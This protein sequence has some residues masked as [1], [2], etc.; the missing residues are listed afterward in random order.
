MGVLVIAAFGV[1][2]WLHPAEI[3]NHDIQAPASASATYIGVE[4][5]A[6]CHVQETEA[7][8]NSH[9]AQAMQQANASTVLGNF[10][11]ARFAKDGLV[12]SFYLK[13][14][15]YY[16]R[17]DGADGTLNDYP[18]AYTF[19]I[20]PLQQYLVSFPN[21]YLQSLALAW[22]SRSKQHGGQHWFHLYPNQT[23]PHTDPLHWTGRNQ[24]WNYMCAECHSTNLRK[25]YDLEKGNYATTWSE[26]NV[27]CE[28]CHGPGSNHVTWAQTQGKHSGAQ[29]D[30]AK[31]LVVQLKSSRGGW[32]LMESSNGTTHWQGQ[33]RSGTELATCAPCHSR[34]HPIKSDHQAGE[35]FLDGYLPSL[36]DEGVYFADGQIQEEDYE[37]GSFVQSRMYHEG[38]TCSDCHNP[39]SLAF[40]STDLN[41]ECGNC[42]LLGKFGAAEHHRHKTN[43]TGAL[44]VNCHMPTRTYMVTDV[45]RD[46][47]F[48]MPRPDLSIAYGTPNA[49]NQC[50]TDKSAKWADDAVSRWYGP[51]RRREPHFVEALDA[52]RR[53]LPEAEKLLTSLINDSSK[54]AIAR[55]TALSLIR[56][57]LSGASFPAVR[58]SLVDNDALVRSAAVRALEPLPE[59][60]RAQLAAPLLTD[61]IRAVRIE[62]ARLLAGSARDLLQ[63]SQKA[64]LDSAVSERIESELISAERPESHMNLGLL[65]TQMGRMKD[66]EDELLTALRLDPNYVPAMVNLA[67]LFRVQQRET[68]AQQFLEKAIFVAPQAA[69]PVHAL[70]LL[71]ARL[72]RQQEALDLFAKAV[73]L[74]PDAARYA[75]V[76][77]VALHSYGEVEKAIAVLKQAHDARPGDREVLS[78]LIAFQRDKGD[79]GSAVVYAEKLVQLSPGDAQALA[80]RNSLNVPQRAGS[81]R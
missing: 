46:H 13:D 28:S 77:G 52:G 47:S 14:E 45:R 24:T 33:A 16:V 62:A 29:G 40:P 22:D 6:G 71:K 68:E 30:G 25:N 4:R 11:N 38:V 41:S 17:T 72:G 73:Q 57:Y 51:G 26:I 63:Q 70:G 55:A 27:S 81:K 2:L 8:R 34:R 12:S 48:R 15:K 7:W 49:C 53:G 66:A 10:R 50:H 80:L 60:A 67:D 79:L 39:H 54:P 61:T 36:L 37:Y 21:G 44:C 43:S 1:A 78:A 35:P 59:Q 19:G 9:H 75:Y 64:A 32:Q 20:F 76:Y 58:A 5:C 23:M 31:G 56:Q 18:V 3:R 69:E 74:Q 65:Y 42:H